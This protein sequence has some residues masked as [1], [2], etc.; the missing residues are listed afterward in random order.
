MGIPTD[1]I[2]LLTLLGLAFPFAGAWRYF[3]PLRKL[4]PY[5]KCLIS[6]VSTFLLWTFFYGLSGSLHLLGSTVAAYGITRTAPSKRSTPIVV[7]C[8]I[9]GHLCVN[10]LW[11]QLRSFGDLDYDHCGPQLVL[12]MK[13][14]SFA[15]CVFDGAGKPEKLPPPLQESAITQFPTLVEFLGYIYFLPG[16]TVGPYFLFSDYQRFIR[17]EV[18]TGQWAKTLPSPTAA[19]FKQLV[20]GITCLLAFLALGARFSYSWPVD[21]PDTFMLYP[22]PLRVAHLVVAGFVTRLKFYGV[23]AVADSAFVLAGLGFR[24]VDSKT[25]EAHWDRVTNVNILK[26]EGATSMKVYLD[27]WNIGTTRWLRSTVYYRLQLAGYPG[28]ATLATFATSAL[29]HGFYPG[30]YLTFLSGAW[31]LRVARSIR[32]IVQNRFGKQ[33]REQPTLQMAYDAITW[34]TTQV[35]MNYMAAAFIC[36]SLQT[37]LKLWRTTYFFVH[38]GLLASEIVLLGVR[39]GPGGSKKGQKGTKID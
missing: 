15:W 23:W 6:F 19:V 20:V 37:S 28:L 29:W 34:I 5:R 3:E 24:E 33:L 10:R 35:T 26:L 8:L 21:D 18:S 36:L 13:A 30:Y 32:R 38:V 7:F 16:F 1:Q 14:T 27:N 9:M 11:K 2:G 25:H 4:S 22:F 31:G 12:V 17:L 39:S